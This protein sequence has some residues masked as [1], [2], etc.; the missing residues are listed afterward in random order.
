MVHLLAREDDSAVER[1]SEN[2]LMQS[3]ARCAVG[4]RA[5]FAAAFAKIFDGYFKRV[6]TY[7]RYRCDDD[8]LADD[9]TAQTFERVMARIGDY[10]AERGPFAAW[11]FGI[12]RNTVNDHYRARRRFPWL[13]LDRFH[14]DAAPDP[15]PEA[16]LI[17]R[18]TEAELVA[19]L[20]QLDRRE[21]DV[22][23]LKFAGE[24]TNREIA[25]LTGLKESNVGVILF[26]AI[27]KLRRMMKDD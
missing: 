17:G 26:R 18:E 11:L 9:M 1:D 4:D 8:A 23:G 12:A 7:I 10:D 2:A 22:L 6:F 20:V 25:K 24:F 27:Q 21:R 5:T 15:D 3:L 19:A 13:S 16:I 14:Q